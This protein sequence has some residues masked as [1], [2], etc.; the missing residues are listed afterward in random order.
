[1]FNV[2][3]IFAVPDEG[4]GIFLKVDEVLATAF[5]TWLLL[6]LGCTFSSSFISFLKETD[7]SESKDFDL[8]DWVNPKFD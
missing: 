3:L 8:V 7:L 6:R 1:M 4:C 5:C 2:D